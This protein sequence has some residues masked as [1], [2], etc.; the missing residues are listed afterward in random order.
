M[1]IFFVLSSISHDRICGFVEG[2]ILIAMSGSCCTIVN[3]RLS[4]E[5]RKQIRSISLFLFKNPA[6]VDN[7]IIMLKRGLCALPISPCYEIFFQIY[8]RQLSQNE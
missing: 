3:Q 8:T 1:I 7:P 5:V 6:A 2:Q 4:E